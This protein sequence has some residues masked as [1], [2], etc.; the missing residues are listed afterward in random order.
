MVSSKIRLVIIIS[1]ITF[2]TIGIF[3]GIYIYQLYSTPKIRIGALTGDLHH[4]PLFVALENN[5]YK[6]EGL[7]IS[8]DNI[9]WF[10]NGNDVMTAFEA[11]SLDLAYLG[12][13]PAMAHK[14]TQVAPIKVVSGVNVN[15]SAIV[16]KSTS[17]IYNISDLNGRKIAV[18][19]KN[20]MQDFILQIGLNNSGIILPDENR[21]EMPVGYM[22]NAL[23]NEE[24]DAFVAW[25]PYNA[26]AVKYGGR[27]LINSSEIWP[28]HPCCIIAA[29]LNFISH[30]KG[31]VEKFVN[32]H[33]KALDWMNNISNHDELIKIAKDY[34]SI[35][36]DSIIEAALDNIGYI[37]NFT[38]PTYMVEIE[39]F[40]D[41]LTGLNPSIPP[42]V[43]DRDDFFQNF[44]DDSFLGT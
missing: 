21:L 33:K 12:L 30:K 1:I 36:E 24:I 16:V 35:S 27:Y 10:Q 20:N 34:T 2:A 41:D 31:I 8:D 38:S 6:D 43:P 44:F 17:T 19:S 9:Y 23:L 25:E 5:F 4:L 15:G 13:A 22:E 39:R 3:L 26:K 11:R 37:F 28:N 42:W 32:V 14:L 29:S 40:Y 18:P 7:D